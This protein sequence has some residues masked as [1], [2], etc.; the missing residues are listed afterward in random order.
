[1]G[2][3]GDVYWKGEYK[4][5]FSSK[6]DLYSDFEEKLYEVVK[7]FSAIAKENLDMYDF[8]PKY[9]QDRDWTII[10]EAMEYLNYNLKVF[11]KG[12]DALNPK[13]YKKYKREVK[14]G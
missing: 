3:G 12:N 6:H 7:S 4:K 11:L 5:D 9:S 1:M 13:R 14:N 2:S 10:D 8:N